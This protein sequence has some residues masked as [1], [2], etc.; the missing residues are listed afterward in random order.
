MMFGL[1]RDLP[2]RP[3]GLR[4]V[5]V[6]LPL[7]LRL[8]MLGYMKSVRGPGGGARGRGGKGGSADCWSCW[9]ERLKWCWFPLW[10]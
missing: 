8:G 7:L 1:L 5:G 3:V 4:G 2:G 10:K 6:V 9:P